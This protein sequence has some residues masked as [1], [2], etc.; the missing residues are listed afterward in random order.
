MNDFFFTLSRL[1]DCVKNYSS[2][3]KKVIIHQ[4]KNASFL[5]VVIYRCWDIFI[6]ISLVA[7]RER[8]QSKDKMNIFS[9]ANENSHFFLSLCINV[10]QHYN[11]HLLDTYRTR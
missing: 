9:S 1:L 6:Y 8:E 5:V 10:K 7:E 4:H 11:S 2:I 3:M